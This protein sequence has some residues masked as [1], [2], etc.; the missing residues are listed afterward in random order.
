MLSCVKPENTDCI[1]NKKGKC[2]LGQISVSYSD[3][4]KL[5][6]P[7]VFCGS[8]EPRTGQCDI[9]SIILKHADRAHRHKCGS[10]FLCEPCYNLLYTNHITEP[11]LRSLVTRARNNPKDL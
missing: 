11:E 2:S 5:S 8:V 7:S 3:S 10:G 4:S 1:H 9:C 6:G